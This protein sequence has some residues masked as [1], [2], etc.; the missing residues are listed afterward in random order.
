MVCVLNISV[1][2]SVNI[3]VNASVNTISVN[4]ILI[5]IVYLISER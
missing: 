4:V 3:S 1:S 2:A 5:G